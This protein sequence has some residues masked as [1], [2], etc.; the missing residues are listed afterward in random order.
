M[1]SACGGGDSLPRAGGDGYAPRAGACGARACT[2]SGG[3]LRREARRF[4]SGRGAVSAIIAGF[5]EPKEC[6]LIAV[7]WQ[8]EVKQGREVEFERFYGADG[9][10]SIVSRK[11]R[12]F[13]G[14]SFLKEFSP[15]RRYLLIEYWSEMLPYERH[16]IDLSDEVERLERSREQML[17]SVTPL[18][19]FNALDVPDRFG[20]TWSRRD[21]R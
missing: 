3:Q 21:G 19:V 14:S 20:P 7:V 5:S 1:A 15:V 13:L 2:P 9:E 12:S 16:R 6:P 17:S 10:W 11:S 18:G 4:R 8:F